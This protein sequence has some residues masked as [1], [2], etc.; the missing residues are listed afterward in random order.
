MWAYMKS[1]TTVRHITQSL[2]AF[3]QAYAYCT[4][5]DLIMRV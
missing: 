5:L 2:G 3:D 4:T 1:G